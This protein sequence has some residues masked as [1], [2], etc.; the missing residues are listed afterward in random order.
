MDAAEIKLDLFRRID[1][2]N[3]PELEKVYSKVLELLNASSSYK[4]STDEQAAI[5]DALKASKR[6]ETYTHEQ[7]MEEAKGKYPDLRFK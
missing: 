4:L 3:Q 1:N 7:V 5:N 6:G 2:L